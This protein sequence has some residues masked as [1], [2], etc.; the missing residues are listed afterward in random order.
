VLNVQVARI[1]TVLTCMQKM[2]PTIIKSFQL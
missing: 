2:L 1:F